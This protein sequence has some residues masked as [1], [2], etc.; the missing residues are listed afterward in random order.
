MI[1]LA[2]AASL[3]FAQEPVSDL[4]KAYEKEYAFLQAE[5]TTLERRLAEVK[6]DADR[7]TGAAERELE[8]LQGRLVRL[9]LAADQAQDKASRAEQESW[10]VEEDKARLSTLVSQ[11]GT[12]LEGDGFTIPEADEGDALAQGARIEA[13]FTEAAARIDQANSVRVEPGV[14]FLPDGTQAT[15]QL[16]RV[17]RVATYGVADSGAGALAPAGEGQLQLWPEDASA[18]ARSVASGAWP[19]TVGVFL[20]ENLE[21]RVEE[22]P[23][24]TFSTL[25]AA[26]GVVGWIILGLGVVAL[27]LSAFR[28]FVLGTVAG[29]ADRLVEQVLPL[30]HQG[31]RVEALALLARGKAAGRVMRGVVEHLGRS[32]EALED[33]AME[34]LL[35]ET[36]R[37]ERFGAAILVIAA[38]APLLGLLGTVTGMIS[39]FDI[40]TEFGTGDP[41]M[42]SGGISEALVTTQ[43]GLIVAIP[44]VLL[45]NAMSG[46]TEAVLSAIERGA[47]TLVN[48]GAELAEG[49]ADG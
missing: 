35:R 44:A 2:L 39:T 6:A 25:M 45:G 34:G 47:L 9:T 16:V 18:T 49:G 32:R 41:K 1:A 8:Q 48:L 46:R 40:I 31:K 12:T 36:P 28:L 10:D 43:L 42:L 19:A 20:Y 5:K 30:L 13:I 11:A 22:K 3:A 23:E 7:R 21:K 26:G 38:V 14:F 27:L 17:G 24:K 37:L 29:D 15:G 4:E 33:V